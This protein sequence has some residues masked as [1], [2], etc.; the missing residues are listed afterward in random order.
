MSEL[1]VNDLVV[2]ERY[3]W[4]SQPERLVYRGKDLSGRWHQF[5]KVDQFYVIWCEVL[6]S[7]LHM[8]ERTDQ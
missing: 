7:D 8:M 6:S 3:N 5:A 1:T 4:K 2:G